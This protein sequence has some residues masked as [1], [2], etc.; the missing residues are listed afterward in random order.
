MSFVCNGLAKTF[1]IFSFF[2][3]RNLMFQNFLGASKLH[4]ELQCLL[5]M[6]WSTDYGRQAFSS[7]SKFLGFR[8][9]FW[10]DKFWG[11]WCIFGQFISSHFGAESLVH[12]FSESTIITTKSQD[13][14]FKSQIFFFSNWDLNLGRK[15]FEI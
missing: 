8:R 14:L 7:K 9:T 4:T 15:E 11:I 13:F 10:A 1:I 2:E 12:V 6:H 5:E 3:T